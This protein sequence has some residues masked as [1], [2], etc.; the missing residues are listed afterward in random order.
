MRLI[1]KDT[2][3]EAE[4]LLEELDEKPCMEKIGMSEAEKFIG[5]YEQDILSRVYLPKAIKERCRLTAC[6]KAEDDREVYLVKG[7]DDR[8]DDSEDSG[9]GETGFPG[10]RISDSAGAFSPPASGTLFIHGRGGKGIH[11]ALLYHGEKPGNRG[12]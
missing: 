5:R 8:E 9:G 7:M 12:E 3:I 1:K 6:L 10:K 11:A 4:Q 2:L